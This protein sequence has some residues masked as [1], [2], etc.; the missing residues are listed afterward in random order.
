[1]PSAIR[2]GTDVMNGSV[3]TEKIGKIRSVSVDGEDRA[4]ARRAPLVRRAIQG[5]AGQE[6]ARH[7]ISAVVVRA[8]AAGIVGEGIQVRKIRAIRVDGEHGA[9]ACQATATGGAKQGVVREDQ[10][11]L[12]R[13]SVAIGDVSLVIF[14][15]RRETI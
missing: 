7:R 1:K 3:K 8:I 15:S 10:C 12:W 14:R 6:Q 9:I 13:S 2:V 5:G 11:G 4:V